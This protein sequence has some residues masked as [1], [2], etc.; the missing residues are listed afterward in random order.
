[1]AQHNDAKFGDKAKI[2]HQ[3]EGKV[4]KVKPS[5]KRLVQDESGN[6]RE[7]KTPDKPID[8]PTQT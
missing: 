3:R 4:V 1:M 5:G 7:E 2:G 6:L 8:R